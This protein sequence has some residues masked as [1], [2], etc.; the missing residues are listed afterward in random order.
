MFLVLRLCA[1]LAVVACL[2]ACDD[3]SVVHEPDSSVD[4]IVTLAPHLAE[5]VYAAG[6]GD[7]LA[8]VSAFTDYPAAATQLPVVGDAFGLDMEALALL[9]PDL[10]L[11]WREGTPKDVIKQLT[12]RGF[13]VVALPALTLE[14]IFGSI[15]QIGRLA[16]TEKSAAPVAA[17]LSRRIAALRKRYASTALVSAFYQVDSK[18]LYTVGGKHFISELIA[19]CGGRNIFSELNV[20]AAQVSAE[21]VFAGD[22][23]V[24]LA[25]GEPG[26]AALDHWKSY[27]SLAAVRTN[28][29]YSVTPSLIGKPGPRVVEGALEICAALEAARKAQ[30]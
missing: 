8:G 23:A 4:T 3:S 13:R 26:S 1:T 22:P 25:P 9:G 12:G 18:P 28:S 24:I 10:I 20:V 30:H 6:A 7:R 11:A 5:L 27:S 15:R 16:G 14:D 17:E 21:S 2:W 19:L 29:L